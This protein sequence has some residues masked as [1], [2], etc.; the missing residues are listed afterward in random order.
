MHTIRTSTL[1]D[2][3]FQDRQIVLPT[4]T[5]G[6]K[7]LHTVNS[8]RTK[9]EDIDGFVWTT[10]SMITAPTNQGSP[11]PHRSA[12]QES[13]LSSY[14]FIYIY[15]YIYIHYTPSFS[16]GKHKNKGVKGP[17]YYHPFISNFCCFCLVRTY[18][19]IYWK[20]WIHGISHRRKTPSQK[21]CGS[22]AKLRLTKRRKK[23]YQSQK[24][25]F[26][27]ESN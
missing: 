24:V 16:K 26:I 2:A 18:I 15:I 6:G 7:L 4:L 5:I 20:I 11:L 13:K 23:A 22:H 12:W 21:V 9:L 25:L 27:C 19:I 14:H 1:K 8:H 3:P 10:W 17:N